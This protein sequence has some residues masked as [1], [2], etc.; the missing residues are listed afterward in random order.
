MR[1]AILL[2][3]LLG[4]CAS[5]VASSSAERKVTVFEGENGRIE[6]RVQDNAI[7][8][9]GSPLRLSDCSTAD[10]HCFVGEGFEIVLPKSCSDFSDGEW[11]VAAHK[12]YLISVAYHSNAI[13]VSSDTS[14]NLAFVVKQGAGV[15][16]IY[17]DVEERGLFKRPGRW[18]D[19]GFNELKHLIF[20][21][22][23]NAPILGCR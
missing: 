13:L 3:V 2:A 7:G 21:R 22:D 8:F 4:A 10:F 17:Y 15:T 23:G 18:G 6:W 20:Y 14:P 19:L 1:I 5:T 12:S 9:N 16:Q 11:H